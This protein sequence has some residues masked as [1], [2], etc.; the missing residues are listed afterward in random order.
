MQWKYET[1]RDTDFV[2]TVTK[3]KLDNFSNS[4]MVDLDHHPIFSI[5]TGIQFYNHSSGKNVQTSELRCG[6]IFD[7]SIKCTVSISSSVDRQRAN[8]LSV[9]Y[10]HMYACTYVYSRGVPLSNI[11]VVCVIEHSIPC[12]RSLEHGEVS[13]TLL[14][15][16]Y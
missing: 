11:L 15:C 2:E 16:R 8:T 13:V 14:W 1:E 7:Q 9:I 4:N 12:G 5:P 10:K 3:V 6:Y